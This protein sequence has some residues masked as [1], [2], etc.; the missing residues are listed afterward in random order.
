M[1]S[2]QS[3]K[4]NNGFIPKRILNGIDPKTLM[5]ESL[6]VNR[7][8]DIKILNDCIVKQQNKLRIEDLF[9]TEDNM[10]ISL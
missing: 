7:E 8:E 1:R 5:E 9:T 2:F 10:P 3:N 6:G 4:L